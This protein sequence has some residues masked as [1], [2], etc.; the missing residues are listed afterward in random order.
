MI[1]QRTRV[2]Y[3]LGTTYSWNTTAAELTRF[4]ED[5]AYDPNGNIQRYLRNGHRSSQI[6]M[7]SLTY[8]YEANTNKLNYIDDK[9]TGA[10]SVYRGDLK[11]QAPN[12]Y[13][14]D[15]IGNLTKDTR[16]SITDISWTNAQKIDSIA[17]TDRSIWF[18]YDAMQNRVV[19]FSKANSSDQEK[20]TY[21][22]RDAQGNVMA[23][24]AAYVTNEAGSLTWDSLR[25]TEQHL[26]GSA[27]VGTA[28]TNEKLYPEVPKN[29]HL[30]DTSHYPIF[31]GWKHYE[32]SNHLGNVLAVITDRKRA[33]NTSGAGITW[34]DADVV[35]AQQYY[36]FGMI[37]PDTT[38]TALRRQY[39]NPN[40]FDKDYR[41]GFNGKEGDD[42]VKGDDNQQ[43]YGMRIYDPR[44]GRFLSVDP[45]GREYPWYTPYQFAGNMPV[46][47]VDLD[48]LEPLKFDEVDSYYT[49]TTT[50]DGITTFIEKAS[51]KS[52]NFDHM[53]TN[54]RLGFYLENENAT[55][56]R[57]LS[58]NFRDNI[59][60]NFNFDVA[61]IQ[62][63][64]K[65]LASNAEEANSLT[66]RANQISSTEMG[67]EFRHIATQAYLTIRFGEDVAK[68]LGD[69]YERYS[70][71][72]GDARSFDL[73]NN[74]R[75]RDLGNQ[76][77]DVMD[78]TSKESISNF[79]NKI[80]DQVK[81]RYGVPLDQEKPTFFPSTRGIDNLIVD[82]N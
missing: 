24:Y 73:V 54:T 27:R 50:D 6:L 57:D 14:Y 20:R 8:H 60:K 18:K 29:P 76:L 69:F 82:D 16:D 9:Q 33:G 22:I 63:N 79:L 66:E 67:K 40:C 38:S 5:I 72:D 17:K 23:T 44:V 35:S 74:Q 21:Y 51:N 78:L 31:E 11:D 4:R 1:G 70:K 3:A 19:K 81:E 28:L 71:S 12:N 48:G 65:I 47:A 49:R 68:K 15:A 52:F 34:F 37:M 64:I 77:K 26:Y 61:R 62:L 10:L 25:L 39:S 46:W 56:I 30:P 58:V 7:D 43:D 13:A 45:I 36:P 59:S 75:G 42:E 55:L 80:A 32:I 2:N 41:Y 53:G